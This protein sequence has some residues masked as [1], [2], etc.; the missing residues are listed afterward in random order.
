MR[1]ATPAFFILLIYG[2]WAGGWE[3]RLRE[4]L[5]LLR[6]GPQ[7]GLGY[8]LFA[9]LFVIGGLMIRTSIRLCRHG[10]IAVLSLAMLLLGIVAAT[11]SCDELH[12]FCSLMLLLLF[13]IHFAVLLYSA[14]SA[15]LFVHLATPL[16]LLLAAKGHSFGLWQKMSIMY[17]VLAAS[18]HAR[19][20]GARQ[21]V[22][23]SK[24]RQHLVSRGRLSRARRI[25]RVDLTKAWNRA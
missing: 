14:G 18:V 20:L 4:P 17:F 24:R 19:F 16:V 5:S 13:Y 2:H 9:L 12:V 21:P 23:K 22:T 15:W 10:E 11:P 8:L 25:Y 3:E 7:A 1:F 6:D